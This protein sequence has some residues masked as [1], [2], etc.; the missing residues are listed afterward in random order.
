MS[1][2]PHPFPC[3]PPRRAGAAGPRAPWALLHR[4]C[5]LRWWPPRRAD[6]RRR[7]AARRGPRRPVHPPALPRK[8]R[9]RRR[10]RRWWRRLRP[11]RRTPHAYITQQRPRRLCYPGRPGRTR[12][13]PPPRR[14]AASPALQSGGPGHESRPWVPPAPPNRTATL[15]LRQATAR[16]CPPALRRARLTEFKAKRKEPEIPELAATAALSPLRPELTRAA[17]EEEAPPPPRSPAIARFLPCASSHPPCRGLGVA[18]QGHGRAQRVVG[19]SS[20]SKA[21]GYPDSCTGVVRPPSAAASFGLP[22]RGGGGRGKRPLDGRELDQSAP[23][24]PRPLLRKREP[25]G[26]G[27][28]AACRKAGARMG[29]YGGSDCSLVSLLCNAAG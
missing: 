10:P 1:P 7:G 25:G 12:G 16:R 18:A 8:Q 27:R 13:A 6:H 9:R 14:P 19:I 26:R 28:L 11:A 4:P 17:G 23:S 22:L 15:A 21:P 20:R 2:H 5:R 3:L 29:F 24:Q